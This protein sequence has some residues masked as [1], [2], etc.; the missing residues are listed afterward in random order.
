[1]NVEQFGKIQLVNADCMEVMRTMPDNAFD[2][3]ICDPPYGLGIDGQKECICK[4]PKHNRKQHDKKG[5]DKLPPP[6]I[7]HGTSKGQQEPNHLGCELLCKILVERHKRLDLLV[8]RTNR[9]N[10]VRL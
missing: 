4:N 10:D 7:L 3:A 1:M 2:L 9:A 5:W 6:R 8:Q